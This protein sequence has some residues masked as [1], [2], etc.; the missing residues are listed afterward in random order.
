M[1]PEE[2]L[3]QQAEEAKPKPP[4]GDGSNHQDGDDTKD[5]RPRIEVHNAGAIDPTKIPPR[6]F[7]LG[8]TFCRK[9]ISGL[10][11]AGAVGKTS[12]R[13][14]QYLALATGRKEITDE[15]VH[16]RCKVLITCLEDSLDEVKRRIAACMLHH[17][18]SPSEV[19]GWLFY[20]TPR[21][22]KLLE[23]DPRG[24]L[25]RGALQSELTTV[26]KDYGI[27]L[28]GLDPFVKAHGVPENDN[29]AID[30][31][32]IVISDLSDDFDCAF[33]IISHDRKGKSEAGDADRDR[34]ASSKRDA[35]RLMRTLTGMTE[36]EAE[37][38]AVSDSDRKTL[39]RVDNAKVNIAPPSDEAMWFRL[40]GVALDNST[41]MYPRGDNVQAV[42]RWYPPDMWKALTTTVC[43][44]ILDRIAA[45]P[46][47][48]EFYSPA[49]NAGEKRRAWPV[50]QECCPSLT[51]GQAK[52]VIKTWLKTGVLK[53]EDRPD[54][55]RNMSPSLIVGKRPGNTWDS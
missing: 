11:S 40:V 49:P 14:A 9:F 18:I 13:Y 34:G 35:G 52:A 12:I 47:P 51:E 1:T 6:G 20:C 30:Q 22:L 23:A 32:C 2:F 37:L 21:G 44:R 26:I 29:N 50:V 48:G 28:V 15:H 41:A 33:D 38:Y 8:T 45:G 43:N 7:L 36:T 53:I 24:V 16:H 46:A 25:A 55:D 31:V 5:S 39:V 54:K 3:R 42:E 10:N 4:N 17:R 27:G 19:D